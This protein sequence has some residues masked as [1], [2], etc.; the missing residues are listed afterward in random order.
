MGG[1]MAQY[2]EFGVAKAREGNPREMGRSAA[3]EARSQLKQLE[4]CLALVFVSAELDVAEVNR[5]V[6]DIL[7]DCPTIGTSTAGE[8]FNGPIT[9]GVVVTIIASRHLRA[10]VGM[11]NHVS[12]DFREAVRQA[13]GRAGVL[14]YFDSGHPFHHMISISP[15][16]IPGVSSALMIVFSPG[17]TKSQPSLSHDIHTY[18]RRYSANR[19]PI[20]GGSSADYVRFESNYQIV[21]G[22]AS[23]DSIA[24]AFV[25]SEVMFGLGLA[26]G[27]SPT[28]RGALI[29]HASDHIVYELDGRPAAEVCAEILGIPLKDLKERSVW[30]SRF[31][32][33]STDMYGNSILQVPEQI[34]DDGAVQFGP[35][36]NTDQMITLMSCTQRDIAQAG[37]SAY[38]KA[39]RQAGLKKP[40]L[41]FMFSCALRKR[42]MADERKEIAPIQD[43]A[44]VPVC[45]F[46]TFG[47]KGLS[48]D[49]LPVYCNQSVS[50]MVFSDEL[51][52]VAALINKGTA[53][54]KEFSENLRQKEYQ[55]RA[56]GRINQ[57]IQDSSETS[58]LL[59]SLTAELSEILPWANTGFYLPGAN[60]G[61]YFLTC[62]SDEDA[63]PPTLKEEE[64][65][66]GY[67]IIP[68][69]G[70]G[71]RSGLMVLQ[72]RSGSSSCED[73]LVF[74]HTIARM[75]TGGL[76]KL[77]LDTQVDLKLKH[78]AILN[79]V[80]RELS[81]AVSH[82]S[83]SQHML[84][85]LRQILNLSFGSLWL[86]DRSSHLL[87]K[88]SFDGDAFHHT[89][90]L[91]MEND[92]KI[93]RWQL[94]AG[95]PLFCD[96]LEERCSVDLISPFPFCFA[97]IPIESKGKLRGIL[98]LYSS[99]KERGLFREDQVFET[100]DLLGSLAAQIAVF[101]DNLWLQRHSTLYKEVHHRIKN[102]LHNIAGLLRMQIRRLDQ[103]SA[104]QA[105]DDSISRI[106]SIAKVHETLSQA[107]IGMI[108]LGDLIRGISALSLSEG[109][110]NSF[111][112]IDVSG[113]HILVPSKEATSV[114][115]VTNELVQNAVKHGMSKGGDG[116]LTI[117]LTHDEGFATLVVEDN[118]P[119]LPDEFDPEKD[120]NLGLTI[121]SSLVKEELK[122]QFS[123]RGRNGTT[124]TV[125][126]PFPM[127]QKI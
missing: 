59:K 26:H 114:A 60:S 61:H 96:P 31:P 44:S 8:I 73:D 15:R 27:F 123:I 46:Y 49:G 108:D 112:S 18:L 74:A 89:D 86:I 104:E 45:G 29:T 87:V 102:N 66:T 2:V 40:V 93:A 21:N 32:F 5:G 121:V 36:M 17:A 47:E 92:E 11:G 38:K 110:A 98:N 111:V 41:A 57:L 64:L 90:S 42:L 23:G 115:L 100:M 54:Y 77:E 50:M 113:S 116:S 82:E 22:V 65:R 1:V 25:E 53:A 119:G 95:E 62:A 55:I 33:G 69:E 70:S 9:D 78:L 13:L 76:H 75:A 106:V 19:I 20:F 107:D 105:L 39:V 3:A 35:L 99:A 63:F 34:L 72:K 4:P 120:G 118:G 94:K 103:K 88:D 24:L 14:D 84:A 43:Y 51:N 81:T 56:I 30:F 52:P 48:D 80:G 28:T 122:G 85:Y 58:V 79:R 97:S 117:R 91:V 101:L 68:M 6:F 16:G 126:F 10:R 83:P 67:F 12:K 127:S 7:H 109:Q 37:L 125:S 71:R 124:A